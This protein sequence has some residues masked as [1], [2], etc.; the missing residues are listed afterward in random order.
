MHAH[1]L[2]IASLEAFAGNKCLWWLQIIKKM[3]SAA[4]ASKGINACKLIQA[5]IMRFNKSWKTCLHCSAAGWLILF[6]LLVPFSDDSSCLVS[7]P[8]AVGL[9]TR[10]YN[11]IPPQRNDY[12]TCF[13]NFLVLWIR[14][15]VEAVICCSNMWIL[16]HRA[17]WIHFKYVKMRGCIE[18]GWYCFYSDNLTQQFLHPLQK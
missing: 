11:N 3:C 8:H 7:Y 16:M 17:V 15:L 18:G 5:H 6:K 1:G 2:G 10:S 12:F 4:S 14:I 9:F 13:H